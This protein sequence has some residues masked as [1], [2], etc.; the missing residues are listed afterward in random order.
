MTRR[1]GLRLG[2]SVARG[3]RLGAGAS[4]VVVLAAACRGGSASEGR[5]PSEPASAKG[6]AAGLAPRGAGAG[7]AGTIGLE[8]GLPPL[9][10]VLEDP[11]LAAARERE[12]ERDWSGAAREVDAARA[13]AALD[14]A[15]ACAWSYLSGRLHLQAGG[16]AEAAAAFERVVSPPD[17]GA[18]CV[19]APWA[20]LREAEALVRVGRDDDALACLRALG[21]GARAAPDGGGGG[22]ALGIDVAS[23]DEARLAL[24]D[25]YAAKGDRASAVPLW[26]ALLEA[27]PH[28]LRWVDT[29]LRLAG[30]LLDG[31]D[32]P[33]GARAQEALDLT[34]RV[35]VE[36]P[37]V[38]DK[39]DVVGLRARAAAALHRAAPPPLTPE[40]RARQAQA[41]LGARPPDRKRAMQSA[42]ALLHALPRSDKAH[43]AAACSAA[44]LRAQTVPHGKAD[45]AADA[46]GVAIARCEGDD[47]LAAALYHG[48]KASAAAHRHAEALARFAEVEKR[49]P[50]H[51]LADDARFREALVIYDDGDEAKYESTLASVADGYPGGDMRGEAL[52]R[53]ALARLGRRDFDGARAALDQ[54]LAIADERHEAAVRAAYFRARVAQLAGDADDARTRYAALVAGEP[55]SFY[56]LLAYDRLRALDGSAARQALDAA[57][58]REPSGPFLTRAH[59]ELSSPAFERFARLLEVGDVDTARREASAAGLTGEGADPEVVWAVA[60]MYDRAGAPELGHSFARA[61]LVDF[62]AHWPA[63]R[64]RLPWEIAYPR[65]WDGVVVRDSEASGIPVPLTWAIMREESAFVP[66]AHSPANAVGLMQLMTGTARL[67]ARALPSPL[68]VDEPALERPDVSI[69]LGTRYL[70]TLRASFPANPALAIAAYNGGAGSVRRWLADRGAGDFDV[71]VERIPFD[72]T[73]NYIKRVLSSEAAYAYLYAPKALDELLALPLRA[74]GQEMIASP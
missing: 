18:R 1:A 24:A 48:G 25:A 54:L 73:R 61:R 65:P 53:L 28:G 38:A 47:A 64:W 36:A 21:S 27:S 43:A 46:W 32:G 35:L 5:P 30:A 6:A 40:E 29:S 23:T 2:R 20:A 10:P 68:V 7:D 45:E 14:G 4:A 11:R 3:V 33:P 22:A 8:S 55:L 16:D 15:Q 34:T 49:F 13:S 62:R 60:W 42:D 9:S 63:G 57:V 71:F 51:R 44:T 37:F 50:G 67:V 52:F 74:S 39:V 59:P 26:R 17:A 56:M 72:E 66:D 58:A 31:V 41:W 69:E 70:A 19:L 12:A